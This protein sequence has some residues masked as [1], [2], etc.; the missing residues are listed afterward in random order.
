MAP[1][2]HNKFHNFSPGY[3]RTTKIFLS[4]FKPYSSLIRTLIVNTS[5][6]RSQF[7][8]WWNNAEEAYKRQ[9]EVT[10]EIATMNENK[11]DG[12]YWQ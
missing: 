10:Y 3:F 4:R 8:L 11:A 1:L 7:D 2:I 5:L 6:T 12:L 9:D